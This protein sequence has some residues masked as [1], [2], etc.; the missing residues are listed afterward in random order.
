ALFQADGTVNIS[1]ASMSCS[2]RLASS[3]TELLKD[4]QILLSNFGIFC[5]IKKRRESSERMLPDGKG[6][7][8][9][10]LCQSDYELIIDGSSREVFMSEIGFIG[11]AKNQKYHNWKKDKKLNQTQKY[12]SKILEISYV[13]KEAVFD[14]TQHDNN[15]VIF[16]GLVTGQCGEQPLPPYGS[17][18]LGSINLTRFIQ[19]PF[20]RRAS[21]DWDSYRKTI[22]IFTRMLDNV[23]E[24]NGLPLA[25]QR[26]EIV[27]K[28]RHGMGYLGLGSTI[29]MLGMKYGDADSL[30]F[31]EEVTQ[32]LAVEGWKA[33][34]ALAEE[35][36]PG[37]D[38]TAKL[39]RHRRKCCA[40][41]QKW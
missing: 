8:K 9:L 19:H 38:F 4:V 5:R 15:T 36:R 10:Y 23:V 39:H 28:R 11:D 32:V 2:V 21:F 26:D 14:T 17:C 40:Y 3:Y 13:G 35:K 27:S 12:Q 24:L 16:N 34:L 6:G 41:V 30:E 33:A 1:G 20:S 31:T 22:R 18:L 25:Q 37:T 29:T 7:M